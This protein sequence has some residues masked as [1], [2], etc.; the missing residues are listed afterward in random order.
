[1]NINF[2]ILILILSLVSS[3]SNLR[4]TGQSLRSPTDKSA[5]VV[6]C[7]ERRVH[8][9]PQQELETV[10]LL[11]GQITFLTPV[12]FTMVLPF[13]QPI[14]IVLPAGTKWTIPSGEYRLSNPTESPIDFVLR[15]DVGCGNNSQK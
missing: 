8:L 2:K 1:M 7:G 11:E 15:T 9:E 12:R 3:G 14:D 6:V 10:E 5:A 13:G 4:S